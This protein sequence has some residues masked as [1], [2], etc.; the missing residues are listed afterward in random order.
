MIGSIRGKIILKTEKFVVV[1]AGGVGYK[2][3]LSPDVLSKVG[4]LE[5]EIFLFI[6]THVREDAFD[7]YG[8][9]NLE[10][11]ECFSTFPELVP[12]RR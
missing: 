12:A 7:L 8:F 3:A 4:R 5:S 10:E 11:L 1:E 6:H 9:S 2:V